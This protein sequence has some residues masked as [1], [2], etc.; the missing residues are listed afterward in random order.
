MSNLV[1]HF[2]SLKGREMRDRR[3]SWGDEKEA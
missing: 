2:V 3:D 1:G